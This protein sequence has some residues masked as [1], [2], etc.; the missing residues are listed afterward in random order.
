M[1]RIKRWLIYKLAKGLLPIFDEKDII[2]VDK[3]NQIYIGGEKLTPQQIHNIK[4]EVKF[5]N[6]STLK[7]ILNANPNEFVSTLVFEKSQSIID[8]VVGKSILYCLQT[9]NKILEF[10]EK[11][12]E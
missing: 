11:A 7:K 1:D 12:K 10:I 6:G 2:K 4:E 5:Y 9:Q 3:Q 8:L